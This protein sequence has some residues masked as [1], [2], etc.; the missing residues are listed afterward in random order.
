MLYKKVLSKSLKINF[1]K[2]VG[3]ILSSSFAIA[4]EFIYTTATLNTDILKKNESNFIN[5][6][7]NISIVY[8][9]MCIGVFIIYSYDNY[10]KWRTKEFTTFILL[11]VRKRELKT[12]LLIESF[13]LISTALLLGAFFGIVFAKIFFLSIIKLCGF[14]NIPFRI[15]YRSYI[16]IFI[17]FLWLSLLMFYKTQKLSKLLDVKGILKYKDKPIDERNKN[18]KL[19]FLIIVI[20]SCII[21]KKMSRSVSKNMEV[22][23]TNVFISMLVVYLSSGPFMWLINK[24]VKKKFFKTYI[25]IKSAKSIFDMDRR[26]T[27]LITVL[28]FMLISYTRTSYIYNTRYRSFESLFKGNNKNFISFVYIF[29]VL[30]CFIIFST[31]IFYKIS[32]GINMIKKLYSRLFKIGITKNEFKRL[33]SLKL[34]VAFF[35]P[36][37]LSLFASAVYIEISNLKF[38]FSFATA[39]IYIVYFLMLLTGYLAARRKYEEEIFK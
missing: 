16:S 27:F 15:P 20:I 34:C 32:F 36:L 25:Q 18:S 14:K 7:A 12:L 38:T 23:F 31:I 37:I 35:E 19:R 30:L 22:Y 21:Y 2:Y 6:T 29:T 33:I 24:L 13:I 1:F 9:M 8:L 17:L 10:M 5:S 4:I 39:I 3:F 28:S 26:I 11:G